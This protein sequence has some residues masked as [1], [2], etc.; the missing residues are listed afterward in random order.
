MFNR[1]MKLS[2][3]AG[4]RALQT[5]SVFDAWALWIQRTSLVSCIK[6]QLTL[7]ES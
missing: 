1:K 2:T 7:L 3:Y 5:S 4:R 6:E